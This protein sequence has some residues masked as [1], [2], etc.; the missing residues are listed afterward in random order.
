MFDAT[1]CLDAIARVPLRENELGPLR[2]AG[3]PGGDAR[4]IG[5]GNA[6]CS[7][8]PSYL[9][10]EKRTDEQTHVSRCDRRARRG[11]RRGRTS[12]EFWSVPRSS[13]VVLTARIPTLRPSVPSAVNPNAY[14][15]HGPR[16][17]NSN[18]ANE[19][20]LR[21]IPAGR[22]RAVKNSEETVRSAR[23][24]ATE[25]AT[26]HTECTGSCTKPA[27]RESARASPALLLDPLHRRRRR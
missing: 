3:Y 6:P 22:A 26:T 14:R 1:P 15:R 19:D 16:R 5:A 12:N 23:S 2:K 17:A 10:D 7:F 8:L 20:G 4:G 25:H 24:C 21:F 27:A 11:N 9:P 13:P 18:V